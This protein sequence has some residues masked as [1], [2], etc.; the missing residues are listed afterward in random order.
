[1]KRLALAPAFPVTS[2]SHAES[3]DGAKEPAP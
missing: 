2:E 1:M 3:A